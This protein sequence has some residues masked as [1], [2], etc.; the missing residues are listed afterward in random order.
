MSLLK[1]IELPTVVLFIITLSAT[2]VVVAIFIF[3]LIDSYP[4]FTSIGLNF[5]TGREWHPADGVYGAFPMIYGSLIVTLLSVAFSLPLAIASAIL[6]SEFLSERW[7]IWVKGGMELLAGVPSIVYG[8]I[9]ITI[10]NALVKSTFV[11]N[12][13]DSILT[14]SILL[15]IMIL[16]TIMT[17]SEDAIHR[18]PKEYRETA[19]GLGLTRTETITSVVLPIAAS[20][21]LGSILLGIGRAMG[22]TMA[23]MLVIGSIDKLP[24]P[25]YNIFSPSQTMTSKLGREAAEAL[26]SGLHWNALV[27]LGLTLFLIVVGIT[28]VSNTFSKR[29][30]K[31]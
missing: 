18:V 23:V 22:E 29:W 31:R 7:R 13:G 11:L 21:I 10:L 15:G 2:T 20:G 12:E 4:V 24:A 6:V 1:R 28:L 30:G 14:A 16:P 9:G 27:A 25:F 8:L 3:L 17:V 19:W 5:F 26:G